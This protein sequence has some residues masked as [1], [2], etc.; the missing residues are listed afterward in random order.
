MTHNLGGHFADRNSN[1]PT[2]DKFIPNSLRFEQRA[3]V[4]NVVAGTRDFD[5]V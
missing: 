2:E 5:L 3:S 4:D 1:L